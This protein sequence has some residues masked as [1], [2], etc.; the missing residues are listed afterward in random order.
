MASG[1]SNGNA[2]IARVGISLAIPAEGDASRARRGDIYDARRCRWSI[3][4]S[5]ATRSP[6][7][8]PALL[9]E[10]VV[11]VNDTSDY[12]LGNVARHQ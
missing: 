8:P 10:F 5:E 7:K 11:S 2:S 12:Y 9:S 4:P 3:M 6:W 1:R